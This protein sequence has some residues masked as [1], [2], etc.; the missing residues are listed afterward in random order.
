MSLLSEFEARTFWKYEPICGSFSTHPGL[1]A[2]VDEDG[3]FRPF[4]GST[5]VFQL[6][7]DDL[8]DIT[9]AQA[10]L[11]E[12]V[13]DMLACPLPP[14]TL[15]M[16]LHDLVNPETATDC[17]NY[18]KCVHDSLTLATRFIEDIRRDYANHRIEMVADRVVNMVSKSVV[19]MLR[20][21]TEEDFALLLEL[22]HRFDAIVPLSW[23]L[24]PHVTL[25]YFKPG[26]IDGDRLSAAIAPIQ[27]DANNPVTLTLDI[28][29]LTA[30]RFEKMD[31]YYEVDMT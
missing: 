4:A 21:R 28:S 14:S 22:Y 26:R 11:H 27:P 30:Q 17:L 6:E 13:G 18:A 25:A 24:T 2:K 7:K 3:S 15:H 12:E 9:A 29:A 20:S 31:R 5:V 8:T 23:P 16:T 1:S 10:F 19:L